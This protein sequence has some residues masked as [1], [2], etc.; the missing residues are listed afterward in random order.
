MTYREYHECD[1]CGEKIHRRVND[2]PGSAKSA[3]GDIN[4]GRLKISLHHKFFRWLMGEKYYLKV[5]SGRGGFKHQL[6]ESKDM[7]KDCKEE[8][9]EYI[10]ENA[11]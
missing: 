7:C 10:Q 4:S 2:S 6:W 9:I 5:W 1:I 8:M 3:A 11:N